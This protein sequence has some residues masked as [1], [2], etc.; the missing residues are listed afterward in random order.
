MRCKSC[1]RI[2][3]TWNGVCAECLGNMIPTQH[4]LLE[5]ATK[6]DGEWIGPAARNLANKLQALGINVEEKTFDE[7]IK[8]R[9]LQTVMQRV[10]YSQVEY[11]EGKFDVVID[12]ITYSN[13]DDPLEAFERYEEAQ[14]MERAL[15]QEGIWEPIE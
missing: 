15:M 14:I 5:V 9:M 13:V 2:K 7:E 1:K 11:F 8:A 3:Q 10:E 4:F 6:N 12:G